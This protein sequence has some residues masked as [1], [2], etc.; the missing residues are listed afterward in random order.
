MNADDS[1]SSINGSDFDNLEDELNSDEKEFDYYALLNVPR[2]ATIEDVTKAYKHR[3]RIFHPDKHTDNE[4]KA[5]AEKLFLQ[6]QNAFTTLTDPKKRAIYDAVGLEGLDICGGEIIEISNVSDDIRKEFEFLKKLREQELM[7]AR[8]HPSGLFFIK[9]NCSGL[10]R[11]LKEERFLPTFTGMILSQNINCPITTSD[12]IG[13]KGR[14]EAIN[15]I[16]D[17]YFRI[18]WNKSY[19]QN[20]DIE[21]SVEIKENSISYSFKFI[22]SVFSKSY[23]SIQPTIDYF[24]LIGSFNPSLSLVYLQQ[25]RSNV[26]G[27]IAYNIGTEVSTLTTS[28]V[29]SELND[30]KFVASISLSPVNPNARFMYYKRYAENDALYE[31]GCT[32]SFMGC[33]PSLNFET[34]LGKFSKIGCGI[35]FSYPA[36]MLIAN[37]KIKTG[38]STYQTQLVLCD[39]KED[40]SRALVYG[41]LLPYLGFYIVRSVFYKPIERFMRIFGDNTNDSQVYSFRE[42]EAVKTCHLMRSTAERIASDEDRK[43][44]LVIIEAKYGEM[45]NY[46]PYSNQYP[47]AGEKLIDVTIPLQ[48]MV[49]DSQLR[50]YSNKSQLPGFYDPCP[51]KPKMLKVSYKFRDEMHLCAVADECPLNIPLSVHRL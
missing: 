29:V 9:C 39:D 40:I 44:G 35:Q 50:I 38:L 32:F 31:A 47:I 11:R 33:T 36:L 34:K 21:N 4:D 28:I 37:F 23:I 25:L 48:A 10:F 18:V 16:G 49:N 20:K 13:L 27:T 15:G 22:T 45:V 6:L 43:H 24:P 14:V 51:G 12:K 2:D 1:F 5:E 3:C 42:Q 19:S 7:L 41:T 26:Q 30:P 17:G 46:G 8:V